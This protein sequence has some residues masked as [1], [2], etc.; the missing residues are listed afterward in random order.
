VRKFKFCVSSLVK[1]YPA[2]EQK[3]DIGTKLL[4]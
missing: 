1:R 3:A 2:E 4:F